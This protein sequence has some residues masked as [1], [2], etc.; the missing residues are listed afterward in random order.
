MIRFIKT[1]FI[2][3]L[4]LSPVIVFGQG[5]GQTPVALN[6]TPPSTS[7]GTIL[8]IF[9]YVLGFI[10]TVIVAYLLYGVF[11]Y[12]TA[13]GNEDQLK[14][15]KSTM[16]GALISLFAIGLSVALINFI[17]GALSGNLGNGGL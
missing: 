6:V 10:G 1:L 17:I 8:N 12:L 5:F 3:T 13:E 4:F 2:Q 7:G 9:N 15:S 14:E 11:R 16:L